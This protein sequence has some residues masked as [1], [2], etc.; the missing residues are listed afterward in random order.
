[1]PTFEPVPI[2]EAIAATDEYQG[3]ISRLQQGQAGRL[4]L[5]QD[6]KAWT[7]RSRLATAAMLLGKRVVV[8]QREDQ[9]Y[10]WIRR[11]QIRMPL[12]G[13]A[14]RNWA[15]LVASVLLAYAASLPLWVGLVRGGPVTP[16]DSG[17]VIGLLSL[18]VAVLALLGVVV[19]MRLRDEVHD[20]VR[21][22]VMTPL[23]VT[24]QL[25]AAYMFFLEYSKT[26]SDARYEARVYQDPRFQLV[27]SLAVLSARAAFERSRSLSG[28][29][30]YQLYK[31]RAMNDLAYHLATTYTAL[32]DESARYEAIQLAGELQESA[33]PYFSTW[34]T[35]AWVKTQCYPE[36]SPE[37]DEGLREVNSLLRRRDVPE[38]QLQLTFEKYQA[39]FGSRVTL[40]L[41]S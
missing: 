41:R 24:D 19:Y 32:K 26:W 10:Y 27:L 21:E 28:D 12:G 18:V 17:A 15:L 39:F 3:Y 9:I 13:A 8:K 40:P 1:M 22:A 36:G 5:T 11:D 7:V 4:K 6:E 37:R 33:P 29:P 16:L 20:Q 14:R 25:N 31:I 38:Y 30:G 35:L 34:E 2:D 23:Q